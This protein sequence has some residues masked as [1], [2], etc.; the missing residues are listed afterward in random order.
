MEAALIVFA[1]FAGI[2]LIIAVVLVFEIAYAA[3]ALFRK[4]KRAL[5]Q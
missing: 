4:F 3:A 5:T 2:A 1:V